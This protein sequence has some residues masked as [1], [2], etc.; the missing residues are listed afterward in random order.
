MSRIA[1]V[2]VRKEPHYR[3]QA[4]ESGLLRCGFALAASIKAPQLHKDDWLVLWNRKAGVEEAEAEDWERRGGSVI[5]MENGYLA[6]VDKTMYAISVG[7]H[8]G[9]GWFPVGDEDR[10]TKLGFEIKPWREG[11]EYVLVCA[12]RGIGS[13]LMASPPGW[14]RK[15]AESLKKIILLPVKVRSHPGNFVAKVPL[16]T[17]LAKAES[18]VIWSS[19]SGV[20]ALVE[21]VPVNYSAPHW[22]C[23]Q[24]AISWRARHGGGVP[25]CDLYRKEALHRMS[26]GQ[27]H[28]DE[29]TTGEPFA[30]ILE[31]LK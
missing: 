19:G 3:R 14:D 28:V 11:G 16:V 8:N 9:A 13:K 25:V 7:Q 31:G 4:I 17:D 1:V 12:Q 21:G 23:E 30:R 2:K 5:V 24:A 15:M 10:F 22:V 20:R 18:C 29:I 26:H 6:K 27:W